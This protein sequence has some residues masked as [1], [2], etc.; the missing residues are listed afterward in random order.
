MFKQIGKLF[1]LER[2]TNFAMQSG[3]KNRED[4]SRTNP[5][6]QLWEAG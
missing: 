2:V 1:V 4:R 6:N 3:L 5:W